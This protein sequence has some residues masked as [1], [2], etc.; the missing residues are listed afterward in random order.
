MEV[1]EVQHRA[2]AAVEGEMPMEE[3]SLDDE[4]KPHK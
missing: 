1:K 3:H 2:M 4:C